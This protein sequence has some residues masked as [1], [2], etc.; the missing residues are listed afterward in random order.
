MCLLFQI[1]EESHRFDTEGKDRNELKMVDL[2]PRPSENRTPLLKSQ[3]SSIGQCTRILTRLSTRLNKE[4]QRENR[5]P[6]IEE[7]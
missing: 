4:E 1:A 3:A 6:G 7:P 5:V 2:L